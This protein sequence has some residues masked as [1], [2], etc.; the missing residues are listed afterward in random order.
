MSADELMQLQ[1]QLEVAGWSFHPV[2][3]IPGHPLAEWGFIAANRARH[4]IFWAATR[5][6]ALESAL[7]FAAAQQAAA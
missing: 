6:E 3:P 1:E 2:R 7:R 5:S 4:E